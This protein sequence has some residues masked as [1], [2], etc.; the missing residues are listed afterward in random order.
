LLECHKDQVLSSVFEN[1]EQDIDPVS[2]PSN[3][4]EVHSCS[5]TIL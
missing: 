3:P 5:I 2:S 4:L 1:L